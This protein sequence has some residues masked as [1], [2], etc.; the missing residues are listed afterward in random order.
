MA[1]GDAGLEKA[2]MVKVTV[3]SSCW[4]AMKAQGCQ[5]GQVGDEGAYPGDRDSEWSAQS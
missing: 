3:A 5:G 4:L 2:V 1:T